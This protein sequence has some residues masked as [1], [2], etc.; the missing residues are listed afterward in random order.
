MNPLDAH[1]PYP[2][3][4]RDAT[5]DAGLLARMSRGDERALGELYD[6]WDLGVRAAIRNILGDPMETEE[7]VEDVFWQAWRQA[8]R[9]DP[10]RGSVGAWLLTVARSRALDRA[11][12]ARLSREH[13]S[14]DATVPLADQSPDPLTLAEDADLEG[15]MRQE[16]ARLPEEQRDV[17]LL[18]Y[19]EG[20]SQS[21]IA[22]RSGEPL[23]TVKTRMRLAMA[24]LRARLAQIEEQLR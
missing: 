24:K 9:F 10:A 23:G 6:R 5:R 11:R 7:V 3:Q 16:I 17:M 15:R 22:E 21:E 13:E 8:D 18:A 19:Q 12:S 14:L 1:E 20:L 4:P 2:E